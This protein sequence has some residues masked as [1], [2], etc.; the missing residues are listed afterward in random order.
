[1]FVTHVEEEVAGLGE[2]G[3]DRLSQPGQVKGVKEISEQVRS[4]AGPVILSPRGEHQ[5]LLQVGGG[6]HV[7][8]VVGAGFDGGEEPSDDGR[9]GW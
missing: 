7:G 9:D 8:A 3:P 5:E 4:Y 2:A 1:M 6:V